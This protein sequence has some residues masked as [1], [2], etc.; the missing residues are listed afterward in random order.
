MNRGRK[1]ITVLVA[2]VTVVVCAAAGVLGRH[3][4]HEWWLLRALEHGDQAERTR[5]ARA[6]GEMG[7]L[8]AV[9]ILLPR[10]NSQEDYDWICTRAVVSICERRGR[11]VVPALIQG[12]RYG[13]YIRAFCSDRLGVFGP[14][15]SEA[16]PALL[17][18]LGDKDPNYPEV[19]VS[20]V[21]ALR[22][23]G[24]AARESVHSLIEAL[25]DESVHVVFNA[26]SALL[27]IDPD[28]NEGF[29]AMVKFLS[30]ENDEWRELADRQLRELG[31]LPGVD[32]LIDLL[33][34]EDP[35]LRRSAA[36]VLGS[37]EPDTD[38]M[39]PGLIKLLG[40]E[41]HFVVEGALSALERFAERDAAAVHK[42]IDL[43]RRDDV[44]LAAI[45]F[46][47][48]STA[49][50][51]EALA[52]VQEGLREG[53]TTAVFLDQLAEAPP[54]TLSS[55]LVPELLGFCRAGSD[56]DRRLTA[57]QVLSNMGPAAR[58]AVPA[59]EAILE[60]EED[61]EFESWALNALES[62]GR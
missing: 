33:G 43:L 9:P 61:L 50:S 49:M 14:D 13:P 41:K 44:R 6:L 27:H 19:R 60:K 58:S 38:R 20:A 25:E 35:H 17:E 26:A 28:R 37:L 52:A 12:L 30:H 29:F 62:I 24:P 22:S 10:L 59:L 8:K 7:C 5:A 39:F 51:P 32:E 3:A 57:L 16:V 1:R 18:V 42:A 53:S 21:L 54:E 31:L 36:V 34:H 45:G 48:R 46:L 4:V 11:E 40:D 55:E 56:S 23:M 47:A 15:A 2:V